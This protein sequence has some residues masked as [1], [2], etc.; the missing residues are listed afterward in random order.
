MR[1]LSAADAANHLKDLP[2][3]IRAAAQ[4]E[5]GIFALMIIVVSV[6]A[7]AFFKQAKVNVRLTIFFS[8]FAGVVA[9]GVSLK[10]EADKQGTQT[11]PATPTV[12][13]TPTPIPS[14]PPTPT[15]TQTPTPTPTPQE[16]VRTIQANVAN[17]QGD[18]AIPYKSHG[19]V[20]IINNGKRF[21]ID[22]VSGLFDGYG[23]PPIGLDGRPWPMRSNGPDYHMAALLVRLD[24]QIPKSFSSVTKELRFEGPGTLRFMMNDVFWHVAPFYWGGIV[25]QNSYPD[26]PPDNNGNGFDDNKGELD[27]LIRI[28]NDP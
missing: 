24:T 20:T 7:W 6:L 8:F 22:N 17:W 1:P 13:P 12:T 4:S 3:I 9:F 21:T 10:A 19:I 2:E 26:G 5:L 11:P 15:V 23:G 27:V 28:S 25:N 14:P 18:V 16:V